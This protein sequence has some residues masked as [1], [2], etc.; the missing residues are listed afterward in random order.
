MLHPA[1]G[2]RVRSGCHD[3]G[4]GCGALPGI[5]ARVAQ[6]RGLR[7]EPLGRAVALCDRSGARRG[8]RAAMG[9]GRHRIAA[10]QRGPHRALSPLRLRG[11]AA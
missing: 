7:R 4:A 11:A 8:Q 1:R 9:R 3:A 2:E 10:H 5:P 6:R